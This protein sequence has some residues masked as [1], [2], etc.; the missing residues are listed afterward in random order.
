MWTDGSVCQSKGSSEALG[1]P[2]GSETG[3][4]YI[5]QPKSMPK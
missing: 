5:G 3:S 2:R 1:L 4:D